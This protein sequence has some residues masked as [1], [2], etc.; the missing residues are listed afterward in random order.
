MLNAWGAGWSGV[1]CCMLRRSRMG[2]E[3]L[4]RLCMAT[5]MRGVGWWRAGGT[6]WCCQ[7]GRGRMYSTRMY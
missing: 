2:F 6:R 7:G 5:G 1:C 4:A 3:W